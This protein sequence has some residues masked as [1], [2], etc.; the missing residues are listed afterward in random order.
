[1]HQN[2]KGKVNATPAEAIAKFKN[3]IDQ[4][5]NKPDEYKIKCPDFGQQLSKL[6]AKAYGEGKISIRQ[7]GPDSFKSPFD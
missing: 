3:M 7:V 6:M 5:A 2:K 4:E 1:M